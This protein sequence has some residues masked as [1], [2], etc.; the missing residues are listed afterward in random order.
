MIKTG[1]TT[2]DVTGLNLSSLGTVSGLYKKLIA[3]YDLGKPIYLEFMEYLSSSVTPC[4]VTLIRQ[5][6]AVYIYGTPIGGIQVSNLDV[7]SAIV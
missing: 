7:V 6:N 4:M 1:Y 5:T 2:I 3:A